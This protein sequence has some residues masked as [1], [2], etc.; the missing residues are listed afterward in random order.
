MARHTNCG[1]GVWMKAKHGGGERGEAGSGGHRKRG[2]LLVP[3][4][5]SDSFWSYR[6]IMRIIG[7]KAAFPPLGLLTFA[8][9]LPS[10]WDLE[11]VD[12]N[13]CAP[14]QGQL[15]AKM[16]EA[17]AVFVTAMSIQKRSLVEILQGPARGLGVP[18]VL[19][20]PFASSY[21]DQILDPRSD[22]DRVLH[23]GLDALVW[24]EAYE[25]I[26]ALL[27]WLDEHPRHTRGEAPRLFIPQAVA[28]V[29]PGSRAYLNDRSIFRSLDDVPLP[30]WDLIRV[31]DYHSMMI[32]TTAGCPFRCD[33][34]DIIQ[35]NGGFN[36]PK[37]PVMVRRELEALLATGY[38]GS[39]FGVDD[40]FIGTPDATS[41]ILDTIIE[42]Q[43]EHRYPFTFY[44][45]AS[46]NLGTPKLRHLIGKMKQA[47]FDAVFLGI[48]TPDEDALRG[49]NKKQNLK[50]DV[51]ETI[52]AI[53]AAGIE[54]YAGFIFGSDSDVPSTADRIVEFVK[55]TR[56]FTAMTGMLTPVPHTPLWE[57][58]K[59]QG[60]L[61]PAEYSGNNTDDEVQFVPL[62][63]TPE[64]MHE[65]IHDILARLFNSTESY[66]RALD[67]LHS[68]QAHI[69]SVKRR[70]MRYLRSALVSFWRQGVRRLDRA[71]FRLL[72]QAGRL[73]RRLRRRARSD[74]RRLRRALRTLRRD[75]ELRLR[76]DLARTEE[77]LGHA[78]DYLVRFRPDARLEQV[79]A[80]VT[81][82]QER[83]SAG[84]LTVEDARA[85]YENARRY[86]KVQMRIHRFPGVTLSRA[87]EAAIK[88]LHY[89]QVM[90]AVVREP[91][92]G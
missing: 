16:T 49:M 85:V 79:R 80:W 92:R 27:E 53:Q 31:S 28:E 22:S 64:Q 36:R 76:G 74:A 60:R 12:L 15:R 70:E 26:D 24:G 71:Y 35:F 91:T 65:G 19:G 72:W 41:A 83:L 47:G 38:R 23:D 82:V 3:E 39:V 56:I 52:A 33:F 88:G 81:E 62:G 57:R 73:D 48:E 40:N 7:R 69:F 30:R 9:Y 8:G 44:T 59:N 55:R 61:Q 43:R 67:M 86:L 18:M 63:M 58:L 11:V 1:G 77:W 37:S 6:Y 54:V 14:S 2:L 10:D 45:Q 29:A 89:E 17:S 32:Q 4:F 84:S 68:V 46:V 87:I 50:V 90:N 51:P 42:F 66:R 21:R 25:S 5:P 34:C 75:G 20:G 13:V 78:H